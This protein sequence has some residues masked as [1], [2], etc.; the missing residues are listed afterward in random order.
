[1]R[2]VRVLLVDDSREFLESA[3]QFLSTHR[4]I[5]IVGCAWSGREALEQVAALKP[6]LV[7]IDL[8]MPSMNGLDTTRTI[9]AGPA[10]PRIVIMTLHDIPEYRDAAL[11][12]AA[13]GFIAKSAIGLRLVPMIVELFATTEPCPSYVDL[14]RETRPL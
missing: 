13:D 3:V 6:D 14:T 5:E 4:A 8:V 10:A 9:K 12:A 7:L 2:S 11:D 1:M